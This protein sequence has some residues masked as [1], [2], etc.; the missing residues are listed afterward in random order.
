MDAGERDRTQRVLDANRNRALEALRVVEDYARFV[1]EAAA[2]AAALKQLRHDIQRALSHPSLGDL[3]AA[4]D[5]TG[6]PG[7]PA[8]RV[9]TR[10]R[11]GL[12][13]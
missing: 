7:R 3:E 10:T 11:A 8:V 1:A 12:A 6:D 13:W 2:P 4:R 5:V 9:D